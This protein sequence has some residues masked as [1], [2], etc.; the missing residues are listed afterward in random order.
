VAHEVVSVADMTAE[1]FVEFVVEMHL[2]V[3]EESPLWEFPAG[4]VSI[5]GGVA[6]RHGPWRQQ[7][8]REALLR[9]LDAGLIVLSPLRPDAERPYLPPAEARA[10]L[11]NPAL[12][13]WPPVGQTAVSVI[14]SPDGQ[15]K[16]WPSWLAYLQPLRENPH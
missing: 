14:Q 8:C 15:A 9:W 4:G 7:D 16:L 13:L 12:W 11:I 1:Q 5:I 2:L 3:A 10:A 6:V